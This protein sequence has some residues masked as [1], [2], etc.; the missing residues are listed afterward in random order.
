MS[1]DPNTR[2]PTENEGKKYIIRMDF[3][4]SQSIFIP[5]TTKLVQN[6]CKTITCDLKQELKLTT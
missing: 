3:L 5:M 6:E 2:K 1:G 4:L